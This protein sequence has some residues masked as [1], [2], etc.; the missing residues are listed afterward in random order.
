M[1]LRLFQYAAVSKP[2][3]PQKTFVNQNSYDDDTDR[4]DDDDNL[5]DTSDSL[6]EECDVDDIQIIEA[7]VDNGTENDYESNI[8]NF[9]PPRDI[10]VNASIYSKEQI[11]AHEKLNNSENDFFEIHNSEFDGYR[12]IDNYGYE[13][14][15]DNLEE[16]K[17]VQ[18]CIKACNTVHKAVCKKFKCNKFKIIFKQTCQEKCEVSF[19]NRDRDKESDEYYD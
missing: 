16:C 14:E 7:I 15:D 8:K 1:I 2:T 6:D 17:E 18:R 9:I 4:I 12:E 13:Q 10:T 5:D 3:T 11:N 19:S